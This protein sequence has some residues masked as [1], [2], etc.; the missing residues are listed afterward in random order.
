MGIRVAGLPTKIIKTVVACAVIWTILKYSQK[1]LDF[2]NW[3]INVPLTVWELHKNW[4][5]L[6]PIFLLIIYLVFTETI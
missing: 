6:I 3:H 1:A 4:W 5:V 2:V